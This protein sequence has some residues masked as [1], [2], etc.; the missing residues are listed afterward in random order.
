MIH[1]VTLRPLCPTR[2]TV[3]A[4]SFESVLLNYEHLLETL[5]TI[6]TSCDGVTN[7]EVTSKAN[8]IHSRLETFDL[9]FG[10]M[11]GYK[12]Y[13]LTDSLSSSLQ[14]ENVMA[15]D[16]KKAS[17][18]VCKAIQRLRSDVEVSITK[19][20][21]LQLADPRIPKTRKSLRCFDA[22]SDPC[23]FISP[24][25]YYQKLNLLI[26]FV[27]KYRRDLTRGTTHST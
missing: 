2:R 23:T 5:Y 7:F 3:K 15:S 26:L 21:E 27:E 16:A 11:L 8:G 25:E 4:K 24:K 17:E 18:T 9:L 6:M 12:L 10:V 13:S 1:T 22:G 19:G 20:Q 14:G